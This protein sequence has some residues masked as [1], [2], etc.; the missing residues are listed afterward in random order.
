MTERTAAAAIA[1][2]TADPPACR[3]ATP[4]SE[5]SACADATIPPYATAA[6]RG[7]PR[8]LGPAP[9]RRRAAPPR[10]PPPRPR[11]I[12][13]DQHPPGDPVVL[14]LPVRHVVVE[15]VGVHVLAEEGEVRGEL[16]RD[17]LVVGGAR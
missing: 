6:A 11:G 4:A 8:R 3:I 1:A 9:A 17:T 10:G 16:A 12:H 5:A 13:H 7:R 15:P 14:A 2:S